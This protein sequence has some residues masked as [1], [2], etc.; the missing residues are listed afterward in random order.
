MILHLL[1][2]CGRLDVSVLATLRDN[3]LRRK[4]PERPDTRDGLRPLLCANLLLFRLVR[5]DL[6]EP[7]TGRAGD[8][9]D[10]AQAHGDADLLKTL[11]PLVQVDVS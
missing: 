5:V 11:D 3:R 10:A 8:S 2:G 1:A 6:G 4:A 7:A 9:H